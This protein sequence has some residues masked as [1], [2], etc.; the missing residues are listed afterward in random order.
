MSEYDKPTVSL[1]QLW[2]AWVSSLIAGVMLGITIG[3]RL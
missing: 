2:F 1:K 3:V